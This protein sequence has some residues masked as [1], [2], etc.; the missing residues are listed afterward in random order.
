MHFLTQYKA[1]DRIKHRKTLFVGDLKGGV[2]EGNTEM[3]DLIDEG[4]AKMS[5][6][7]INRIFGTFKLYDAVFA[8]RSKSL[9]L[10][11]SFSFLFAIMIVYIFFLKK[12]IRQMKIKLQ[13]STGD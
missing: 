3:I 11:I 10:Y 12:Q 1:F 5:K 7:E 9:L 13:D 2:K 6:K 4:I 8:G